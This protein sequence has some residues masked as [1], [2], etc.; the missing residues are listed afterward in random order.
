MDFVHLHNHSEYSILDGAIRIQQLIKFAVQHNMSAIALTDHGNMFGIIEF[1]EEARKA[2][3]KPIIGQEFYIAPG[4]RFHKQSTRASNEENAYHLILLAENCEGYKNLIKLSS[5]G[6]LE[7][8]YYKP[9]IDWELLTKYNKGLIASTSCIAGE[10]PSLILEGKIK[11]AYKRT[12]E[13]ADL[14]GKDRFYLELQYHNLKEQKQVNAQLIEMASKMNIGLI[15]TNDA[16][17][18]S[19]EDAYYHD[20]LLCIQTGK[21]L[22]DQS[23]MRFPN[24]QFYLKTPQEMEKIFDDYP[25]ALYNTVKIA[26]MTDC[27]IPLGNPILPNF[28]V[29]DGYTKDSY[30]TE[31][32]YNGARQRFGGSI[33]E[34]VKE[35][36]DYELSVIKRMQFSGYFLIVW[37]F[38]QFAKNN[39]IPVGPGRGSAAG[40]MVSYC[41]GITQLDPIQYNLLF[42]RFLNPERNEM[43][44]MDIDFCALRRD[45]VIEYVKRKYGE[46]HVSQ[47][48][49]FN[50]MKSKG[51]IRDV[52]RA[53]NIPLP[54]VN[55]LT[56]LIHYDDLEDALKNSEE[57]QQLYKSNDAGKQLIDIALKVEGLTRSA[58][59]HAAGVVISRDPLTE[60]VPLY[61]DPKDGSISSQYEKMSLE[62]AGLVKMDFLGLANLTI[63]DMCIRLIKKHR[64]I[65]IDINSIPLDDAKTFKL[66]QKADTMGVFQLESGGM[67]NILLKLGPTNLDDIIAI[68]ALYRPG[69]LDSGMVE[70]YIERKRDPKKIEYLHP[71]LEPILKDTLGVIVYQEQVMLISQVMGGFTLPEA[72]KLRKAMSKK[73]PEIIDA[74]GTKFV[75]GAIAKGIDGAIATKTWELMATFGRYGFNKSH[76]AAYALVSYQT[77]YLKAHYPLEFM[78]ALLTAQV[79]KIEDIAKYYADCKA[80]GIQ[81]LPP[82]INNS[83]RDFSI[84]GKS[85]RYGLIAIKGVGDKA[86][87][88]IL[89]AREKKSGF[90]DLTEFFT[91]IDL[92][93][94]NKGVLESLIKAGAFDSLYPNRA[95]LFASVDIMLETARQLQQDIA[96]GQGDLFGASDTSFSRIHI[97]PASIADWPENQKLQY[98]KEVLG[99]YASSHPLSRYAKDIEKLACTPIK[100]LEENVNGAPITLVGVL[101]NVQIKQSQ[102]G[103]KFAQAVME[104]LT[105]SINVLFM[106][107]T[108]SEYESLIVSQDPVVIT[109]TVEIENDK[110][111]RMLANKVLPLTQF[112]LT[113]ISELHII[114]N[115]IG[116]DTEMLEKI[117]KILQRYQGNK[118]VFFHVRHPNG[119]ENIVKANPLYHIKPHQKLLDSLVSIVGKDGFFYTIGC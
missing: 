36:I 12:Q 73:L 19:K 102:K 27:Q 56:K 39:G 88:S 63:I 81:V 75:K 113:Q 80:K 22:N 44:D 10:I 108:L 25:D 1:Y 35:R 79:D 112:K 76:S 33:P 100:D 54:Q 74:M 90:K 91:S 66:L 70:Q 118:P 119:K 32:V 53:L 87:E 45:E 114:I 92:M 83:Q 13:F 64:N 96:T 40:S 26:E 105:G 47:I 16:H 9:R 2:G 52:A 67:Q 61:V 72:D 82:D 43:P 116:T 85:I 20:V 109:G 115:P 14:F 55:A 111:S 37:D 8:F 104:D 59:K 93:T 41:L 89:Q 71:S 110:P 30:L 7:G 68:V 4:S 21:L 17:Y 65:D 18:V 86:I 103:N 15:A 48:I 29:P 60:Y 6:Y 106:P 50:K 107:Q 77:A 57:L 46:D 78:T 23:R 69:P 51:A 95:A 101:N 49:T 5:L 58:G 42:E 94:V 31:L 97:E 3:I 99:I 98:E 28:D 34:H 84:E 11:E 38:I 117:K 62:K 24:D